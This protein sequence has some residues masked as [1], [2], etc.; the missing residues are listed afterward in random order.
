MESIVVE[1]GTITSIIFWDVI[2]NIPL[3][4][5]VTIEMTTLLGEETDTNT[6]TVTDDEMTATMSETI[7]TFFQPKLM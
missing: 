7:E 5:L 4:S 3:Y 1:E 6:V 2:R